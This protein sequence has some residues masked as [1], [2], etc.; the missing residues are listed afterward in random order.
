MHF[1]ESVGFGYLLRK[2]FV[3]DYAQPAR[4]ASTEP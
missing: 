3:N 2:H 4:V 1:Y